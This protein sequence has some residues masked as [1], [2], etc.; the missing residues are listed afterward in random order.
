M[1]FTVATA[2]WKIITKTRLQNYPFKNKRLDTKYVP[3]QPS[4]FLFFITHLQNKFKV[5]NLVTL[6]TCKAPHIFIT[7]LAEDTNHEFSNWLVFSFPCTFN[8]IK[9]VLYLCFLQLLINLIS[10]GENNACASCSH[11]WFAWP[12]HSKNMGSCSLHYL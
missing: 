2:L 4:L 12:C 10:S 6:G 7:L 1:I 9:P 11:L 5:S 3:L 8:Y